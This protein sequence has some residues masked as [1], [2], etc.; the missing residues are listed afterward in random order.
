MIICS[1]SKKALISHVAPSKLAFGSPKS[2]ITGEP[3]LMLAGTSFTFQNQICGR[4]VF[5][6]QLLI[7]MCTSYVSIEN[8]P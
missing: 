3:F 7:S 5:A 8:L 2:D 1:S 4:K 6:Y